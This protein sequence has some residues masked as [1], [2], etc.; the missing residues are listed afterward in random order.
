MGAFRIFKLPQPTGLGISNLE[1]GPSP[2]QK[3]K[4]LTEDKWMNEWMN[5]FFMVKWRTIGKKIPNYNNHAFGV[6]YKIPCT[7]TLGTYPHL[8]PMSMSGHLYM[9]SPKTNSCNKL[10]STALSTPVGTTP[11]PSVSW[12]WLLICWLVGSWTL[13]LQEVVVVVVSQYSVVAGPLVS[14]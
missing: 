12:W 11:M 10:K 7:L 9:L 8:N 5:E 4:S 2:I 1:A 6:P 3:V 14:M 13:L